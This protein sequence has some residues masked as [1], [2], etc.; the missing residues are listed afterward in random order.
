MLD[1]TAEGC[2][3]GG[4]GGVGPTAEPRIQ[5]RLLGDVEVRLG[6]MV[7]EAFVS[8]RLQSLLAFLIV[9]RDR[10]LARQRVAFI[11]WP[12]SS[13]SQARTNLR[14]LLH[15]LRR[16]LVEPDRYVSI[17][18]QTVQWLPDAPA[19]IDI[20]EFERGGNGGRDG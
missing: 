15:M 8:S 4:G 18:G 5:I 2:V 12:D 3:V 14:H 6:P 10:P 9:H 11:F 20:V 19:S 17:D 7:L 1:R 16:A 13:E